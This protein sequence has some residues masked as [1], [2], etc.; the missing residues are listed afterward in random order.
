MRFHLEFEWW[1]E[2]YP[3]STREDCQRMLLRRSFFYPLQEP[4]E[5]RAMFY[6]FVEEIYS[7]PEQIQLKPNLFS[8]F[9]SSFSKA[10]TS[11]PSWLRA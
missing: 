11:S 8:L 5:Y 6:V 10:S 1:E 2:D 7:G 4:E 9:I 3:I